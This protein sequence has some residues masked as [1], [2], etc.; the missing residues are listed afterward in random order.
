MRQTMSSWPATAFP[1]RG[2]GLGGL[3]EDWMSEIGQP[4]EAVRRVF[5]HTLRRCLGPRY[6]GQRRRAKTPIPGI[7]GV[8]VLP[9]ARDRLAP[10]RRQLGGPG[11]LWSQPGMVR[12]RVPQR[13]SKAHVYL[14]VSG[15]MANLLPHLLS[16][17]LPYVTS[18]QA[19]IFQF[20]TI[21]EALPK[22]RLVQGKLRTTGGT[23][24]NCVL[25]HVLETKPLVRRALILTDG[26]TGAPMVEFA[27]RIGD[28][29]L[30]V[31]V[32]LPAE[33]AYDADLRE[34]AASVVVLPPFRSQ[35]SR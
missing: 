32:V 19:D 21:V 33:S 9:N 2:R 22:S 25:E 31:H 28:D 4:T 35:R 8:S 10:A 13:P 6:G 12:A 5:A 7:T 16:L 18:G 20:S 17:V 14:D 26:Y 34:I 23:D 30:R 15:S 24:I 11:T 29:N 3:R 27:Q 1:L